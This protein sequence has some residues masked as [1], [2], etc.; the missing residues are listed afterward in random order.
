[1]R[2]EFKA[3]RIPGIRLANRCVFDVSTV[4]EAILQRS[5]ETPAPEKTSKRPKKAKTE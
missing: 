1:M 2:R 3:G 5:I 4:R